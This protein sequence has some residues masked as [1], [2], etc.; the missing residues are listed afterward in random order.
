MVH[1]VQLN[2]I[3]INK[4]EEDKTN[5]LSTSTNEPVQNK[6]TPLVPPAATAGTT[7]VSVEGVSSIVNLE[8]YDSLETELGVTPVVEQINNNINNTGESL[9]EGIGG[10]L[11]SVEMEMLRAEME[12]TNSEMEKLKKSNNYDCG[13][14][15]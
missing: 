14:T 8:L 13:D 6:D 15:F 1:T 7:S 12:E 11:E 9:G 3:Q 5:S 10:E 2:V 4:L